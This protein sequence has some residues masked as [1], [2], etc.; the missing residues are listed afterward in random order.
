MLQY[1]HAAIVTPDTGA[2][3]TLGVDDDDDDDDDDGPSTD[4][5]GFGGEELLDDCCWCSR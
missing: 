4:A 3:S 1:V 2:A 5:K